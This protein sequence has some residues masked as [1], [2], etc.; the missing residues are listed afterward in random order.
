MGLFTEE[1]RGGLV[2]VKALHADEEWRQGVFDTVMHV[3][4]DDVPRC[5]DAMRAGKPFNFLLAPSL[6]PPNPSNISTETKW[7]VG[8]EL[9]NDGM[10]NALYK[11]GYEHVEASHNATWARHLSEGWYRRRIGV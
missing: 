3:H 5:V 8:F 9:P 4:E 10:F 2:E 11:V 6:P 1:G 7:I